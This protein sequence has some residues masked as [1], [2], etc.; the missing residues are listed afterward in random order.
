MVNSAKTVN[1]LLAGEFHVVPTINEKIKWGSV[2][3]PIS[4]RPIYF[5]EVRERLIPNNRQPEAHDVLL[6]RVQQ[7]GRHTGIEVDSGRKSALYVGD[8]IGLAFGNRYA[9]NQYEGEV[10]ERLDQYHILSQ[11]GVCGRVVTSASHM[12]DPTIVEPLGYLSNGNGQ[13]VNLRDFAPETRSIRKKVTTIVA[14]GSSMDAGKTTMASSIIRGLTNAGKQVN[15]G[16]LTGTAC[17]KDLLAML[18]AGAAKA[19]DFNHIGF[20]S[21]FKTSVS[22]LEEICHKMIA[23]LSEDGPDYLVLEI[24]DGII[25]QETRVVLDILTRTSLVDRY[26]LAVH[27]A[28]AA[29]TCVDFLKANW[30]IEPAL[31]SGLVTISPLSTREVQ[32]LVSLPCYNRE[33][34]TEPEIELVLS[35][36]PMFPRHEMTSASCIG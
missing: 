3:R 30:D 12:S 35:R 10:P 4:N 22:E 23:L 17:V 15:S 26:C 20:A 1:A 36:T 18:D 14:I 24:A 25:Q 9:T 32:S 11:G 7:I 16:K 27:D 5:S 33:Q 29:P 19:I 13:V 2:T 6:A 34:L 31:V 21:T 8:V 28:L